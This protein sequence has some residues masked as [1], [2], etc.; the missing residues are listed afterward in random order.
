MELLLGE[1]F[2]LTKAVEGRWKAMEGRG[3][4]VEGDGRP[5]KVGGRRWKA[6]EGR[7]KA[8]EGRCKWAEGS[9]GE[10]FLWEGGVADRHVLQVGRAQVAARRA[11]RA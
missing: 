10:P 9:P 6:V 3:M 1:P 5:W 8:M 2:L 7:W 11:D 4:S